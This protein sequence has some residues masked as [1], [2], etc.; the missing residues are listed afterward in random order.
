MTF[1]ENLFLMILVN[2][3]F[4]DA[5]PP[6]I[7]TILILLPKYIANISVMQEGI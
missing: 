3:D 1:L 6:V 4:P 5:I 7:P 2:T